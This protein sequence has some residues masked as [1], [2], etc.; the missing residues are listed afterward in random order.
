M[1]FGTLFSGDPEYTTTVDA[2]AG[3]WTTVDV[4]GNA[5]ASDLAISGDSG[6]DDITPHVIDTNPPAAAIDQKG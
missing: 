5:L 3:Q 1:I 6:F 2:V 4:S